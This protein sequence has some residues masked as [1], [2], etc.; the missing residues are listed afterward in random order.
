MEITAL[1][2]LCIIA[3][4]LALSLRG[5]RPEFAMLLS[6]GCGLFVLLYLLGQMKDIFSGLEDILSGLSGQSELTAIILK[7]LGVC[8]VAELGSQCC[9][10]AGETA[11][12]AKV[13]L[14][15]KAALVMMSM[16]VFA[17][18]LEMAGEL[19][20]RELL[21]VGRTEV[22]TTLLS[23]DEVPEFPQAER[24]TQ[25]ATVS[26]L[27]LDAVLAA[28]LHCS[29][30]QACEWIAAGRVEI[31]HLP[32]ESAHAPV[33]EGDVFTVRGKGRFGLTAL[34]GKSKKDRLIIEFFQY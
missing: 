3:A 11:I 32:A 33:Y 22:T 26:S 23:L 19:I 8:I 4:L 2:V 28:M 1:I 24:K 14:A 10:D 6:L 17:S 15:A 29:R 31:N 13:E 9:R 12:A 21:Q 20:C 7:A 30:G 34:P 27:R 5:Q 25:T 18:L 16:P